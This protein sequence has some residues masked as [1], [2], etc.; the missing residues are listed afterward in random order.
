MHVLLVD[1]P[2]GTQVGPER[3][4]RDLAGVAID[5]TSASPII[6]PRPLV[7]AMADGGGE[8]SQKLC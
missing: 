6:I 2:E 5:L 7:H 4:A 8:P 3:C 1:A